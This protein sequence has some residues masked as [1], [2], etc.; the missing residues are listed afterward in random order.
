[1]SERIKTD[2]LVVGSGPAG[3]TTA[4]YSAKLG[5]D[6]I[7]IDKRM[8]IGTPVRCGEFIPSIKEIKIMFPNFDDVDSLF[9][10]P[11]NLHCL[12]TYG[13]KIVDPYGK[14]TLL[15]HTGYTIDRD[16]FDKYLAYRAEEE[17]AQVINN[18]Q[19]MEIKDG[20]ALTTR[21]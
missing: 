8:E 14:V 10:I 20:I 9:D 21:G 15:D 16:K 6:V 1:M 4:I 11:N 13:I 2:V 17:G 5:A 19:F 18:C 7:T 3:S 12:D